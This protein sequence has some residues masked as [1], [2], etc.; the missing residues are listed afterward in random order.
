MS[1]KQWDDTELDRV[2][3]E[4]D[5]E[6]EEIFAEVDRV[7][8]R[9]DPEAGLPKAEVL[10]DD[11]EDAPRQAVSFGFDN[12]DDPPEIEILPDNFGPDDPGEAVVG[13]FRGISPASDNEIFDADFTVEAESLRTGGSN[14][15]SPSSRP[16]PG[17][18]PDAAAGRAVKD[19]NF[20]A[21]DDGDDRILFPNSHYGDFQADSVGD[22]APDEFGRLIER[23]VERA[24]L[25][26]IA[27]AGL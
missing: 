17:Q 11:F 21:S 1:S 13:D 18:R 19:E 20:D 15:G 2:S 27:K 3:A 25:S 8:R 6:L 16:N 26:A 23:A 14:G 24:I 10:P 5:A 22:M 12:P 7:K 9:P 4:L